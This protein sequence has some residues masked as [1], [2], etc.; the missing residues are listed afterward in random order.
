[1]TDW[2]WGEMKESQA[3]FPGAWLEP[4]V[5][6]EGMVEGDGS[7]RRSG[8]RGFTAAY[9]ILCQLPPHAHL[10]N[11]RHKSQT[12]LPEDEGGSPGSTLGATSRLRQQNVGKVKKAWVTELAVFTT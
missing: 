10:R 12:K 4:A 2:I 6:L 5:W 8:G 11:I 3:R 9:W 7:D 1:M